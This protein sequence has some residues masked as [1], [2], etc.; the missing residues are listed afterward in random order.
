MRRCGCRQPSWRYAEQAQINSASFLLLEPRC[1]SWSRSVRSFALDVHDLLTCPPLLIP[2]RP[3]VCSSGCEAG[4]PIVFFLGLHGPDR[5]RH[6][7]CQGHG[8]RVPQGGVEPICSVLPIAPSTY[9]SHP[10]KRADPARQSDRARR[11]DALRPEILRVFEENY[12]VYGC[13]LYTSDAADE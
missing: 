13:L 11:D 3:S 1:F 9:Y 12:R 2:R 4:I 10:A 8:D 5:A 7:V 6:L